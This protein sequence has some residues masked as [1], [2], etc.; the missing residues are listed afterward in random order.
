MFMRALLVVRTMSISAAISSSRL[1]EREA[2]RGSMI[3]PSHSCSSATTEMRAVQ[4]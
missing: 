2:T 4:M 1:K 3:C